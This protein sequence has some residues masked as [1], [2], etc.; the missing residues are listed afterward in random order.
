MIQKVQPFEQ[1]T[2]TGSR[3]LCSSC[4]SVR[5]GLGEHFLN[6]PPFSRFWV[7]KEN[8]EIA[9]SS[10]Q[11]GLSLM[12]TPSIGQR[13]NTLRRRRDHLAERI[14]PH[15]GDTNYDKS[16]CSALSWVIQF[17]EDHYELLPTGYI[18]GLCQDAPT[19]VEA[20]LPPPVITRR[21]K[22]QPKP[23]PEK[24]PEPPPPP[25]KPEEPQPDPGKA[26]NGYSPE[27]RLQRGQARLGVRPAPGP[28][29]PP[30]RVG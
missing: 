14:R 8:N 21:P 18:D 29:R 10:R 6:P 9:A 28:L 19:G 25:E 16:E 7:P 11:K 27:Q 3:P 5:S 12:S 20:A 24:K 4:Q 15:P 23:E 17:V 22:P 1:V 26:R 30:V 2:V 13:L